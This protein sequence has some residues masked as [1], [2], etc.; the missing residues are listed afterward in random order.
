MYHRKFD[1]TPQDVTLHAVPSAS[2]LQIVVRCDKCGARSATV[3]E[4]ETVLAGNQ[5]AS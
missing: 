2:G 3:L 1:C 4:P 5:V